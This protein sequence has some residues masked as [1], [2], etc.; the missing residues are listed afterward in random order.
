MRSK[1]QQELMLSPHASSHIYLEPKY[2]K[3]NYVN[4]FSFSSITF[5]CKENTDPEDRMRTTEIVQ[6]EHEMKLLRYSK[7]HQQI[8]LGMETALQSHTLIRYRNNW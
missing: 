5:K 3:Q 8:P 6:T 7:E 4:G 2:K 1:E